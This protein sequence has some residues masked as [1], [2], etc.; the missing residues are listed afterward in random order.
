MSITISNPHQI[1]NSPLNL[2]KTKQL[3]TFAKT[4]RFTGKDTVLCKV[5][6]DLPNTREKRATSFGYGS[7][8][9]IAKK[10]FNVPSPDKYLIPSEFKQDNTKNM[11]GSS[12]GLGREIMGSNNFMDLRQTQKLPGPGNYDFRSTLTNVSYTMR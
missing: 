9:D 7:K 12:F 11:K 10:A 2:S 6:Y 5:F 8:T 3:Y 4:K 1:A